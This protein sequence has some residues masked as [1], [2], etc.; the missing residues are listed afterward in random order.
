MLPEW[1]QRI[2]DFFPGE[3]YLHW[4]RI[5]GSLWTLAGYVII[6]YLLRLTNLCRAI[7]GRA[8]HR[9]PYV[10]LAA[11]IPFALVIPIAPTSMALFRIELA[12]TVPHFFIILYLL[13]A[14]LRSAPQALAQLTQRNHQ[15]P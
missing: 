6:F 4:S 11:T 15:P 14:N 12:V 3:V 7:T 8:L 5:Q 13:A 9:L 1:I 10:A 2:S